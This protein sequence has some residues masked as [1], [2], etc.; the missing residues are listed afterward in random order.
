M[1]KLTNSRLIIIV[2]VVAIL[3]A[4]SY[5]SWEYFSENPTGARSGG[6]DGVTISTL[7]GTPFNAVSLP[8]E[9]VK[10][11]STST[12]ASNEQ[13]QLEDGGFTITQNFEL[14]GATQLSVVTD[15]VGGTVTSTL[16][17]VF[18]VSNDNS[19]YYDISTT[20]T[21]TDKLATTT[22]SLTLKAFQF[23]PGLATITQAFLFNVPPAKYGRLLLWCDDLTT[24]P[25]DGV[26]AHLQISTN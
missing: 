24:D 11:N 18:Q 15:A 9:K 14:D 26:Q 2:V 4:G 22:I 23:D 7:A 5:Y 6:G 25:N 12:D 10:A 21:T 1:K 16:Y 3:L 20:P 8:T 17:G 19:F 13:G